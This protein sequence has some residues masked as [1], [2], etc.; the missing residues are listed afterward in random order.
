MKRIAWINDNTIEEVQGG[1]TVT[2]Q[3]M[4]EKGRELGH[5]IIF[6][7][8]KELKDL[9]SAKQL[10]TYDLLILNNIN[11]FDLEV[12]EHILDTYPFVKYEHDYCYCQYRNA[13]CEDCKIKPCTPAPIFVK[14]FS[15]SKLNIFFS[16]LQLSIYQAAFKETM[17]DAIVIPPPMKEGE[18]T[19]NLERDPSDEN[20]IRN[21]CY[22]YAGVI[23]SHKGLHQI[24]DFASGQ[25]DKIF[26]FAGKPVNKELL[27]RIKKEHTYL[28][29]IPHNEMPTLLK[30]YKNFIINPQMPETFGIS[31]LEAMATGCAITKFSKT[32]TTGL[33]SYEL[34]LPKLLDRCYNAPDKFWVQI[35]KVLNSSNPKKKD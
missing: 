11:A 18:F 27:E 19:P 16:P 29:E 30:K 6:L 2:S 28:G 31:I 5:S 25:K 12:M 23:M 3:V 32:Y 26:H 7:T 15:N 10:E 35:R 13:R 1:A 20:D 4:I 8:P 22:L 17:R 33:E 24:L 14:L 9:E 34:P 21:R